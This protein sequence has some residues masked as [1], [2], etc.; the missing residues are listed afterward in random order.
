MNKIF[1]ALTVSLLAAAAGCTISTDTM[2]ISSSTLTGTVSGQPWSFKAGETSAFLSEG[3]DDFFATLYQ[4]AYTPCGISEP[5]GPHIIVAI[6]KNAGDYDMDFDHN[7][8]FVG[9]DNSNKVA[10]DGRIVVDYATSTHVV[11]GLHGFYDGQNE[12][13]GQFDVTV[14]AH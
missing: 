13:N 4:T 14:C 6:P 9:S 1:A 12:V 8:T 11:G 2:D 10:F 5:T 7:M 3:K